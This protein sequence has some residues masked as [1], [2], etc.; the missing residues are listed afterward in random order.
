MAEG[1]TPLETQDLALI[2]ADAAASKKGSDIVVI[3]VAELLV[4]TAYFV[5]VTGASDVQ[6]GAI[7]DEVERRMRDEA[8]LKP[9]GREGM[10]RRD[11]VLL[12]YGDVVLHVFQPDVREFYRLEHLWQDAPRLELPESITGPAEKASEDAT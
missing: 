12:D 7:A 1:S 2:A 9:L 10:D 4:V 3:D 8:G 5:V 6:V 11:W